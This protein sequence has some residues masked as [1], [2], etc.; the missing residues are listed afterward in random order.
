MVAQ[1][2][3]RVTG[4]RTGPIAVCGQDLHFDEGRFACPATVPVRALAASLHAHGIDASAVVEIS[5][6][7]AASCRL[8]R[9]DTHGNR[10]VIEEPLPELVAL[11]KLARFESA[12]HKQG[13]EV[14]RL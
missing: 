6:G 10:F 2:H 3:L 14:E 12:V 7:L 13:Y 9:F 1:H 8:V 5:P 4:S 11:M